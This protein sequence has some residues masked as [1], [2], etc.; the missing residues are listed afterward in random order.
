MMGGMVGERK[1]DEVAS[2]AGSVPVVVVMGVS[3]SGKTTLGQALSAGYGFRF[4]D[5]DDFHPPG[6]VA[7]MRAGVPLDDADRAPW[8]ERLASLLAA[9]NEPTVLACSAL[10]ARYRETLA[11][12][13]PQ[14]LFVHLTG[15][16]EL[17]GA[18]LSART[19]HYMP[20]SLLDSQMD[21]LEAPVE[22]GASI[23]LHCGSPVDQLCGAV[24]GVLAGRGR[25]A[26]PSASGQGA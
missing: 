1:A 13:C 18:R 9:S 20:A 22:D 7:K 15:S 5:A 2:L 14:A 21:A 26:A 4:L 25:H 3:G 23:T 16:R 24:L 8:L 11:L 12:G 10:K 6:N 19:D 17:I